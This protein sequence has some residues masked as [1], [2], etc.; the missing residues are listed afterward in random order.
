MSIGSTI[1]MAGRAGG[2]GG[3]GPG[4]ADA[5]ADSTACGPSEAASSALMDWPRR[6][7]AFLGG[8]G[9]TASAASS[10]S[11][12]ESAKLVTAPAP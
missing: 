2:A 4:G 7:R 5:G 6:R 11:V 9:A 3:V 10:S 1:T 8:G 12:S